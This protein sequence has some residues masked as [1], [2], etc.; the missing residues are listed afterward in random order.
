M[1][2][3]TEFYTTKEG[4]VSLEKLLNGFPKKLAEQIFWSL[5]ILEKIEKIAIV[6][7]STSRLEVLVV[8]NRNIYYHIYLKHEDKMQFNVIPKRFIEEVL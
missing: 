3:V 2:N 4:E 7:E 1:K 6:D 5:E 8:G